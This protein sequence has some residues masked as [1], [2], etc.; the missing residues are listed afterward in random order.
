MMSLK[1]KGV[2]LGKSFLSKYAGCAQMVKSKGQ[3]WSIDVVIGVLIFLIVIG[4]FYVL[5][6]GNFK[7]DTTELQIA[8]ETIATKIVAPKGTG[9]GIMNNNQIEKDTLL[10]YTNDYEGLKSAL[11]VSSDFCI[12][13]EDEEGNVINISNSTHTVVGVGSSEINV[14]G[15][16]CGIAVPLS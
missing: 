11:G 12:F 13:L 16:P 3:A 9:V 2:F 5:L 8:S 1:E 14:S 6:I 15:S 4:L 10:N 7:K